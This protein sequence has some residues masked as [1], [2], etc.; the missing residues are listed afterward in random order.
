MCIRDRILPGKVTDCCDKQASTDAEF[1]KAAQRTWV[2]TWW[3]ALPRLSLKRLGEG[4]KE[5]SYF[6]NVLCSKLI[7]LFPFSR[8]FVSVVWNLFGWLLGSPFPK[9]MAGKEIHWKMRKTSIVL[10]KFFSLK[11]PKKPIHT[12]SRKP[13]IRCSYL[14]LRFTL[15]LFIACTWLYPFKETGTNPGTFVL[16]IQQGI[17]LA[18]KPWS[19]PYCHILDDFI[20]G[21][22]S[23]IPRYIPET[24]Q[25]QEPLSFWIAT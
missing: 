20:V 21:Y 14:E 4:Q 7:L 18:W 19:N 10:W 5:S 17:S 6:S 13:E 16:F 3:K 11:T 2:L 8:K 15:S 24:P 12:L 23:R 1:P 25:I 9:G 22:A